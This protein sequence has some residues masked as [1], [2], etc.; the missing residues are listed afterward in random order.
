MYAR[1]DLRGAAPAGAMAVFVGCRRTRPGVVAV[2]A[3]ALVASCGV[4]GANG[5]AGR[6]PAAS[7]GSPV[8]G[9][10]LN[11]VAAVP[12]ASVWAVGLTSQGSVHAIR[13]D[14]RAWRP[15]PSPALPFGGALISVAA[16]SATSAW[17]VGVRI[18][19][20][21]A[22]G[23]IEHW[24]GTA[25]TVV[26][27][28]ALAKGGLAGVTVLSATRAWAVGAT[29]HRQ[30]RTLTVIERWNGRSWALVPSPA[31]GYLAGVT[32]T[33][34]RNAWAVG[35]TGLPLGRGTGIIEHWNGTSWTCISATGT[36]GPC[37]PG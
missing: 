14:G 24:N 36:A 1:G 19:A 2:C 9:Y 29:S 17:A 35:I 32:A 34:A 3:A 15:V 11:A 21:G 25:W 37:P 5:G 4:A 20:R 33:S 8:L 30:H 10:R 31:R 6:G 13:W 16:A 22:G 18:G 12:G 27:S 23:L 28:P 26:P 7:P